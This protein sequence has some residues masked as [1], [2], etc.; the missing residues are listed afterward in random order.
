MAVITITGTTG[1]G[2]PE[3]GA[4]VARIMSIDYVDEVRANAYQR[5]ISE[6]QRIAERFLSEGQ[7]ESARMG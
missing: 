2:A 4:E 1:T 7:G 3:V 5:M 6:R